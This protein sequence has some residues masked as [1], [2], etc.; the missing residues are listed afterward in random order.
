MCA[1]VGDVQLGRGAVGARVKLVAE[2]TKD[3]KMTI[4]DIV[5]IARLWGENEL[6][7]VKVSRGDAR[8]GRRG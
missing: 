8:A 4:A 7:M 5:I 6:G 2:T 1:K 3:E